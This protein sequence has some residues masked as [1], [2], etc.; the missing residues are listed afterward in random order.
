MRR[1]KKGLHPAGCSPFFMTSRRSVSRRKAGDPATHLGLKRST[2]VELAE[3]ADAAE[4]HP[5]DQQIGRRQVELTTECRGL[6]TW[7][8]DAGG[9]LAQ[10]RTREVERRLAGRIQ[11]RVE[12]VDQFVGVDS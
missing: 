9:L 12:V 10:P 1:N 8:A 5:M 3:H 4:P 7:V 2:R 11:E 6:R